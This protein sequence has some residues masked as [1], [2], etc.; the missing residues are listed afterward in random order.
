MIGLELHTNN[1]CSIL[2]VG[3]DFLVNLEQLS[4]QIRH[5]LRPMS[6]ALCAHCS[7]AAATLQCRSCEAGADATGS[8]TSPLRAPVDFAPRLLCFACGTC[9]FQFTSECFQI[10]GLVASLHVNLLFYA[11]LFRAELRKIPDR[12]AHRPRLRRLHIRVPWPSASSSSPPP[13][14]CSWCDEPESA[15]HLLAWECSDCCAAPPLGDSTRD[16]SL[17][18]AAAP[19]WLLHDECHQFLHATSCNAHHRVRARSAA[20][21][22]SISDP[23]HAHS[24]A[25]THASR[26]RHG[27]GPLSLTAAAAAALATLAQRTSAPRSRHESPE[28]ALRLI[29]TATTPSSTYSVGSGV[30]LALQLSPSAVADSPESPA[31]RQRSEREQR[32]HRLSSGSHSTA[33]VDELD[34]LLGVADV[35]EGDQI[36]MGGTNLGG[37]AE[38]ATAHHAQDAH[39]ESSVVQGAAPAAPLSLATL[40]MVAPT[41]AP[42]SHLKPPRSSLGSVGGGASSLGSGTSSYASAVAAATAA[43]LSSASALNLPLSLALA[44]TTPNQPTRHRRSSTSPGILT[45]S[46]AF[47]A[48]SALSGSVLAASSSA[49]A[50]GHGGTGPLSLSIAS[51]LILAQHA[52]NQSK[53]SP[54]ALAPAPLPAP[55]SVSFLS[56]SPLPPTA[57]SSAL[58]SH[59]TAHAGLNVKTASSSLSSTSSSALQLASTPAPALS[60]PRS[61]PLSLMHLQ[62]PLFPSPPKQSPFAALI[63]AKDTVLVGDSS[64]ALHTALAPSTSNTAGVNSV[65]ATPLTLNRA[66]GGGGGGGVIATPSSFSS[67]SA[68]S[69]TP[70]G[71]GGAAQHHRRAASTSSVLALRAPLHSH[72]H[73]HTQSNAASLLS[74][75]PL[76]SA[77]AGA[78]QG[79]PH[80]PSRVLANGGGT[81]L[82]HAHALTPPPAASSL[83]PS[84]HLMPARISPGDASREFNNEYS[85]FG[86]YTA[87]SPSH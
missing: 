42:R 49:T 67:S 16:A 85:S 52:L 27:D 45:P 54:S 76:S 39:S 81:G 50:S 33:A 4:N 48:Q 86:T 10:N 7:L 57:A 84:N 71:G 60:R 3:L 58:H 29:S 44:T 1:G 23:L 47:P 68:L 51:S 12:D 46:L 78:D 6:T 28:T 30:G 53:L 9:L 20:G 73:S 74:L 87:L 59:G 13:H 55:T 56:P 66:L 2:S 69:L 77:G 36:D 5:T 15:H 63:N 19:V 41:M 18:S 65:L 40:P 21:N 79:H 83:S 82:H 61:G 62:T 8:V 75:G 31:G 32:R 34:R 80:T 25:H 11:T 43:S 14:L 38:G 70:S 72:T 35:E 22:V 24:H 64:S 37:M 26:P 17:F